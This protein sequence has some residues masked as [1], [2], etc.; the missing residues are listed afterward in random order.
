VPFE[1]TGPGAGAP[2]GEPPTPYPVSF[3]FEGPEELS[4]WSTIFRL[5]LMIP[6][7]IFLA[8]L[9]GGFGDFSQTDSGASAAAAGGGVFGGLVIAYWLSILVRGGRPVGWLGSVIVA[10]QRFQLRAYTYF[11]LLTDKYP[12]FEGSWIAN[13]EAQRPERVSRKQIFFWKVLTSIPHFVVLAVLAFVVAFCVVIA[14]FAILFT[15]RF[16]RGLRDFVVGWLRWSARVEAYVISLRDEF[17]PYS[18]SSTAGAG[19]RASML[20][21]AAGGVALIAAIGGALVAVFLALGGSETAHVSYRDLIRGDAQAQVEVSNVVVHLRSANDEFAFPDEIIAP[22]DGTRFI[23]FEIT[24]NNGRITDLDVEEDDFRLKDD[25]GDSHDPEF[26]TLGG[27]LVPG[28][29]REGRSGTAR[30]I[31]QVQD[32]ADPTRLTYEPPDSLKK[33]EFILD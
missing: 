16:P 23:E 27:E 4:R 19:S 26:V 25:A 9:T 7:L 29:L 11:M 15:K 2:I 20:W 17:P 18:L 24:I 32:D 31:F 3:E 13:Y 33:A 10:I 12:A 21:S 28:E 5:F 6:V 8:I 30:A 1:S 14:W 22:E